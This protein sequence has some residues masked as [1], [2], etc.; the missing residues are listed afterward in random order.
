MGKNDVKSNG[1]KYDAFISYRH[2]E[3]DKFVAET[4]HKQLEAFRLPSNV[5]K[6]IKKNDPDAKTRITRVFRDEEELPLA[7]NLADPIVDALKNSE[8]LIVIC[9]PRL[10]ESMW[11]KKEI[12]TFIELHG[13]EKVL[14]VLVEGEPRDSFPEQL[15]FREI[16]VKKYDGT[17]EIIKEPIEPLAAD[18]RGKSNGERAK[19]I[20]NDIARIVAPMFNLGYDELKQRHRERRM[21]RIIGL[22]SIIA[23]I[24]FIF[25]VMS[26]FSMLTIKKQKED[27]QNKSNE[28]AEQSIQISNQ[29][30]ELKIKQAQGLAANSLEAIKKDDKS[31]AVRLAYEALTEHDGIEM[32]YCDEAL[33]ALNMSLR[34]YEVTDSAIPQYSFETRGEIQAMFPSPQRK[35][36]IIADTSDTLTFWSVDKA[37]I[38]SQVH[39]DSLNDNIENKIAFID[40]DNIIYADLN[41]LYKYDVINGE[42]KEISSGDEYNYGIEYVKYDSVNDVIYYS[43]KNDVIAIDGKNYKECFKYS[44][45][46]HELIAG[47]IR[48]LPGEFVIV[49]VS[50]TDK[51]Y[52][53]VISLDNELLFEEKFTNETFK[54]AYYYDGRLFVLCEYI[55]KFKTESAI[56]GS[57]DSALRCF[58]LETG[59][60]LWSRADSTIRGEKLSAITVDAK[61]FLI[62]IG[63]KGVMEVDELTGEMV[64]VDNNEGDI[65]WSGVTDS[66]LVYITDR[67]LKMFLSS[68]TTMGFNSTIDSNMKGIA[69]AA[70][71]VDG[72]FMA[73]KSSNRVVYYGMSDVE[74]AE[75][76]HEETNESDEYYLSDIYDSDKIEKLKLEDVN[77]NMTRGVCFDDEEEYIVVSIK[78]GIGR[79]YSADSKELVTEFSMED[80]VAAIKYYLG[81]DD[82]GNR[83]WASDKYGYVFSPNM[84]VI[85]KISY[86][87]AI[88]T[89][90]NL[91]IF[92]IAGADTRISVPIYSKD[93]LLKM[94]EEFIDE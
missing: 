8:W 37:K 35:Y 63:I 79:I 69:F 38:A 57:I 91:Y 28:I 52:V 72:Y 50:D 41:S 94:A 3:P 80:D 59:R 19:L 51:L 74:D 54:D 45:G 21:K 31:T 42:R 25:G 88:D 43:N 89:E 60:E 61:Q 22:V 1:Y 70:P 64:V 92:G 13:K 27:I 49:P 58:S 78:G 55:R 10:K 15:T 32:P 2:C 30:N 62:E 4:L 20:K 90:E 67:P 48:I 82:E 7:N 36:L 44:C 56:S 5:V 24:C 26:T 65:L 53:R 14:A 9:S 33:Y 40:D 18:A 29:N 75:E 73:E 84:N 11:C 71:S 34:P 86:L 6:K 81:M 39:F 23:V 85:N 16:E 87:R 68:H 93:D 66:A 83:Y 12:D 47:R 46:E 76:Y 77:V 17:K